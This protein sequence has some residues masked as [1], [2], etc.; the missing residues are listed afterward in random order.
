MS[1]YRVAGWLA[2]LLGLTSVPATADPENPFLT[3]EHPTVGDTIIVNAYAGPCDDLQDPYAEPEITR[4]GDDISVLLS[5][6]HITDPIW[7]VFGSRIDQVEIGSF[8]P[9]TYT[10]TIRWQYYNL[11]EWVQVTLGTLPLTIG[12]ISP[13]GDTVALPTSDGFGLWMLALLLSATAILSLRTF[14][15]K[16]E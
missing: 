7:C 2:L 10:V 14:H 16:S 8:P 5:G 6:E 9:G 12:E 11:I 1:G 13:P 4:D 3:P 15:R